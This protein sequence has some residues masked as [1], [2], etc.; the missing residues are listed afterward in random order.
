VQ[1]S[2]IRIN[3]IAKRLDPLARGRAPVKSSGHVQ[4]GTANPARHSG[5]I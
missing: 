4:T 1:G 5:P 2:D 3:V